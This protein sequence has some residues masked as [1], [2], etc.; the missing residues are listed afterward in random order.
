L[1]RLFQMV[2]VSGLVLVGASETQ[3]QLPSFLADSE[4]PPSCG[5]GVEK[6]VWL[7]GGK[8]TDKASCSAWCSGGTQISVSCS[9]SCTAVDVNCPQTNGYVVC[10]GVKTS[11]QY[12]CPGGTYCEQLNG[13]SCPFRG[14][15]TSCWGSDGLAYSCDCMGFSGTLH[16]L[17]P[18]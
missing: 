14:A 10:N 11:C 4:A 18:I 17:C 9:G 5:T 1:K 2:M 3:A 7:A 8:P 12:V 16:W 15:T 13:T 6:A